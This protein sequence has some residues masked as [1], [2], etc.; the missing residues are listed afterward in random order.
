MLQQTHVAAVLPFYRRFLERFPTVHALAA[1]P[2][3][4]VLQYWAGLGYYSRARNLHAAAKRIAERGAFPSTHDEIR[5]LPGVGDYTAAAIASIAFNLPHAVL[6]GNV[7]RV[8]A[9]LTADPGDIRSTPVRAQLRAVADGLL[10]REH[11][12]DFNQALMEL[13]ATVCLPGEPKCDR[14][15]VARLCDARAAGRQN[16]LPIL[17]PKIRFSVTDITLLIIRSVA[18][19]LLS[20][21]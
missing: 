13:G 6:D 3:S 15:P 12:G 5:E 16:E 8:L 19:L 1:A 20:R 7:A 9:R 10:D 4:D 18:G 14:C 11:P 21:R 2:E 17:T